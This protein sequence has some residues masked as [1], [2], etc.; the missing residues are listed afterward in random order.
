MSNYRD[1]VSASQ[2]STLADTLDAIVNLFDP[3]LTPADQLAPLLKQL[4]TDTGSSAGMLW[5]SNDDDRSFRLTQVVNISVD[6]LSADSP[7]I[8][9]ELSEVEEVLEEHSCILNGPLPTDQADP[10][11]QLGQLMLS[12]FQL[13][14]PVI[15]D[16]SSVAVLTLFQPVNHP[17]HETWDIG[18]LE[19][20]NQTIQRW[21]D[22]SE[23]NTLYDRINTG[24]RVVALS[25]V[26]TR[27]IDQ[28]QVAY[29]VA[30]EL[31]EYFGFG[32]VSLAIFRGETCHIQA[33][34]G[35]TIFDKRS[36]SITRIQQLAAK[37]AKT[38]A[39][40]NHPEDDDVLPPQLTLLLEKYYDVA[41][42]KSISLIP[43]VHKPEPTEDPNDLSAVV[44]DRDSSPG[45]C[46]GVVIIEGI[47]DALTSDEIQP[48]WREVETII[49]NTVANARSHEGLFLMPV[50]RQLGKGADVFRGHKKNKALAICGAIVFCFLI[51]TLF[52]ATLKLRSQGTIQPVQRSQVYAETEGIISRL[53]VEDGDIVTKDQLLIELVNPEL[54]AQI[55]E[56]QGTL[57]EAE[58]RYRTIL[59]QRTRQRFANK[60]ELRERIRESAGLEGKVLGLKEQLT[61][62]R[63]KQS[64]LQIKSPVAGQVV[65]W[66]VLRRLGGRPVVPGQ[67]LL[68][69]A[70]PNGD[71]EL[72]LRMPD[73]RS[74]HLI[75]AWNDSDAN[76]RPAASYVLKSEPTRIHSGVVRD[77]AASANVHD[78]DGNVVRVYVDLDKTPAGR[79]RPGTEVI[80]HVHAG[81]HSL[82]YCKLY[83]FFDW[84]HRMSF[85]HL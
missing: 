81:R 80:A 60:E 83:E 46:V 39:P 16:G 69:V 3:S 75:R 14:I 20:I 44:R 59:L 22:W 26:V 70:N 45:N 51:L 27:N 74:G 52:P 31:R 55:A 6:G 66:D 28:T 2:T 11:C 82:G 37:V 30:N 19:A 56:V 84:I 73:K 18:A 68:T 8:M 63:E 47:R 53:L 58:Q 40:L 35:Q 23:S 48:A 50:W 36:P 29:D 15:W 49:T 54:G 25:Q 85:S 79:V 67:Q 33:V 7:H 43:L 72:E 65:T 78:E 57:I 5:Q 12:H 21:S 24:A 77:V 13:R 61:L 38:K 34:S 17:E 42:T 9:A 76:E 41:D 64:Q 1:D 71:W 10:N 32:R 62:L 4:V